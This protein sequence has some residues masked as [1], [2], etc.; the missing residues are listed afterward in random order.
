MEAG[1]AASY[2]K[3]HKGRKYAAVVEIHQFELITVETMG[4]YGGSIGVIMRVNRPPS[5]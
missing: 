2:A 3:E 5:C 1:T 4:G